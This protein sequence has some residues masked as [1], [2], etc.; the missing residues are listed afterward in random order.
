MAQGGRKRGYRWDQTGV[1]TNPTFQ[2]LKTSDELDWSNV[3]VTLTNGDPCGFLDQ[4]A[5]PDLWLLMTLNRVDMTVTID[6]QEQNVMASDGLP[7]V[8]APEFPWSVTWH[9]HLRGISVFVKRG[10]L[11]EVGYEL[12][13]S[14]VK[15]LKV[16]SR[17]GV[18]DRS[19]ALLLHSLK[20]A[21]YEPKEHSDLKVEHIS[22]ALVAD[23]LCK[24][25]VKPQQCSIAQSQL[26]PKQAELLIDY[27]QKQLS[28]KILLTDLAALAGLSQTAFIQRFK[29]SFGVS[30]HQ[31][32]IETRINLARELLEKSKL[33]IIHVA[34]Q[35]GFSDQAHFT[36]T[37][38]RI[39]GMPPARYRDIV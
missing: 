24:H 28:S 35:C 30:P 13:D 36:S 37:F 2:A 9:N 26:K 10:I 14:D 17:F 18:D 16:I 20:E 34:A 33:P 3:N 29:A 31:Y 22:R 23:I 21:L 7:F 39:V 27:I 19:I 32:V 15:S 4:Q 8:I 6:G 12:F 38:K 25:S 1:A 11:A 5:L